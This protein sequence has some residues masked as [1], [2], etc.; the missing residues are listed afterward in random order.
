MKNINDKTF[1]Q[2]THKQKEFF[3]EIKN[4][5]FSTLISAS[6]E[7][8]DA[9]EL[10]L[11]TADIGKEDFS[12][13]DY[14]VIKSIFVTSRP[15]VNENKDSFKPE[16]LH[17]VAE[18]NQI[19]NLKPGMLDVNHNFI[20]YGTVIDKKIVPGK[21]IVGENEEEVVHL[22]VYSVLWA[23][24]FPELAEQVKAWHKS[25][26][27]RFSMAC[28]AE[29]H[30]CGTCGTVA[31]RV[32]DYCEHLKNKTYSERILNKPKFYANSIITPDKQP[33]DTNAKGLEV[34]EMDNEVF[35]RIYDSMFQTYS[36]MW[37][38][39]FNALDEGGSVIST[40]KSEFNNGRDSFINLF[41]QIESEF[42]KT[43]SIFEV[44]LIKK[45]NRIDFENVRWLLQDTIYDIMYSGTENPKELLAKAFNDG[46]DLFISLYKKLAPEQKQMFKNQTIVISNKIGEDMELEKKLKELEDKLAAAEAKIKD[47]ES[48]EVQKTIEAQKAEI[49]ELTNKLSNSDSEISA[50]NEKLEKANEVQK[51]LEEKVNSLNE[52]I[53]A[54]KEYVVE[55]RRKEVE[56][57]NEKRKEKINAMKLADEKKEFW[58]KKFEASLNEDGEIVDPNKGLY[59]D[60]V[61]NIEFSTASTEENETVN[62]SK[63]HEAVHSESADEEV[64]LFS[65]LA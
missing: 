18:S 55:A 40:I 10:K 53:E 5:P 51:G 25:G 54:Q 19:S 23:W 3:E 44:D 8:I 2:A 1:I 35:W 58:I 57:I 43:A 11:T 64:G 45:K 12:D 28:K 22:E 15:Y 20:G 52:Q 39:I 9:K 37:K 30:E 33:A 59:E 61:A 24:R 31:N 14:L 36:Q 65:T 63:K 47:Y 62:E 7:I 56:N 41:G 17:S 4:D 27:L 60:F 38:N 49:E 46:R 32:E 34:S 29:S 6:A 50:L 48:Q 13:E 16:D 26:L 21:V 42:V